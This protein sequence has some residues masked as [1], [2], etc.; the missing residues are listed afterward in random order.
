MDLIVFFQKEVKKLGLENK[1][2]SGLNIAR[3]TEVHREKYKIINKYGEK[4]ASLKGSVF[5]NDSINEIYPVVGDFVMAKQNELGEDIIFKVLSRK[6]KFSRMDTFNSKEQIVATNFDYV[7]IV[8]SLNDEFNIKRLERYLAISW[9]SGATP[10]IVLTKSD[11]CENYDFYKNQIDKID[12]FA[13]VI[14]VSSFTG[15]GL[16]KLE[17]YINPYETIVF[18]GSS[19]VGK[20]TLVNRISDENIMKV[21]D[22]RV[23]DAKGKHTTTHR[24]LVVLKNGT[25]IIDTPGMRE[26]GMW[27]ASSGVDKTFSDIEEYASI[28]KFTNCTHTKEPG[29]MIIDALATGKIS[30]ERWKNYKK[31]KKEVLFAKKK[32]DLNLRLKE[33]ERR[34]KFAKQIRQKYKS[35]R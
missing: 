34:K 26:I 29:C 25:M 17:K 4:S 20:S 5:Y 12:S 28:C 21:N 16:D 6:S 27:S 3:I 23:G 13:T 31:L 33:K 19:G 35:V 1:D 18:L 2:L 15:E 22:I 11:L 8:S 32:E 10:I 14:K 9:E 30:E 7:F 24:Q